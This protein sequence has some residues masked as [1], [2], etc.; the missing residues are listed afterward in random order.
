MKSCHDPARLNKAQIKPMHRGQILN[1]ILLRLAGIKYITLIDASSD[2]HNL[3]LNERSSCLTM[4]SCPFG[5]HRYIRL[6]FGA[7][8]EGDMFQKNIDELFSSMPNLF[9]IA[10]DILPAGF[11]EQG[12]DHYGKYSGHADRQI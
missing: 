8:V 9:G 7:T 12:K 4:F 3:K 2:Y 10:D 6:P 11:D 5:R 1:D